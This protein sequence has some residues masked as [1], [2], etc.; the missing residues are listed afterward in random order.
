MNEAIRAAY[1]SVHRAYKLPIFWLAIAIASNGCGTSVTTVDVIADSLASDSTA[2]D[3]TSIDATIDPRRDGTNVD[4]FDAIE[5]LDQR[6]AA[7]P[8]E[9]SIDAFEENDTP[10][11]DVAT[12][13]AGG[14]SGSCRADSNA[15]FCGINNCTE[16]LAPAHASPH[17]NGN[18]CAL[19]LQ[20]EPS[21]ADCDLQR[22]NGCEVSLADDPLNCRSCGTAC[23]VPA[24]ARAT[25]T[26]GVCDF[27]CTG[28]YVRRGALCVVPPVGLRRPLSASLVVGAQPLFRWA[29]IEP[30]EAYRIEICTARDCAGANVLE[31]AVVRGA[32]VY[33]MRDQ[34]LN[35]RI[36]FWRV[37]ALIGGQI[38]STSATWELRSI[39]PLSGDLVAKQ[40]YTT[41]LDLN[42]DGREE[43]L[44]DCLVNNGMPDLGVGVFGFVPGNNAG[45]RLAVFDRASTATRLGDVNGDGYSDWL[46][47]AYDAMGV[48]TRSYLLLGRTNLNE[49]IAGAVALPEN[50]YFFRWVG[51]VNDDGFQDSVVRDRAGVEGHLVILGGAN[52]LVFPGAQVLEPNGQYVYA[53]LDDYDSDG[54]PELLIGGQDQRTIFQWDGLQLVATPAN[55]RDVPVYGSSVGDLNADGVVDR[56]WTGNS[57]IALLA[58]DGSVSGNITLDGTLQ[59]GLY[60]KGAMPAGDINGDGIEDAVGLGAAGRE[61]SWWFDVYLG[62]RVPAELA[63]ADYSLSVV[64]QNR[65][66]NG[67]SWI[68][69]GASFLDFRGDGDS[70]LAIG[71]YLANITVFHFTRNRP[72]GNPPTVEVVFRLN[73]ALD[74]TLGEYLTLAPSTLLPLRTR[75]PA[76]YPSSRFLWPSLQPHARYR[77]LTTPSARVTTLLAGD[78]S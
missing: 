52:G 15:L 78:Y 34:R 62:S 19:D 76:F 42:G 67:P 57:P 26:A 18:T 24:H 21:F 74:N 64:P 72:P 51:D 56:A 29:P 70:Y 37:H 73:S 7:T 68:G 44:S 41:L 20:C 69:F 27:V 38:E 50:G 65:S 3:A 4:S 53:L 1:F 47:R 46:A 35:T 33:Q 11:F 6:D 75:S 48:P 17:C 43:I 39:N 61:I 5:P 49:M 2:A 23:A 30:A 36:H 45:A 31:S 32:N 54:R 63:I 25:C 71:K 55:A 59:H 9:A 16:C 12:D 22:A 13:E 66:G 60:Q 58:S 14:D 28:G 77:F 40:R 8:I 10:L